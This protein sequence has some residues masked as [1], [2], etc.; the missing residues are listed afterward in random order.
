MPTNQ[1]RI[2]GQKS[3]LPVLRFLRWVFFLLLFLAIGIPYAWAENP[4]V[5]VGVYE[6]APKVFTN[7]SGKS[8]G[9]FID[10]IE[11][12]AK[13]EGWKLEYVPGT[14]AEGLDRLERGEIDL[15]PDVALTAEREKKFSFHL[16]VSS[17][18]PQRQRTAIDTGPEWKTH[19]DPGAIRSGGS[20]YPFQPRVRVKCH[21]R[22]RSGL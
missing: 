22:F 15:M 12:I 21:S 4:V 18:C 1:N 14:W 19:C 17:L 9:I 16:M 2:S 8:S 5:K 3:D 11:Y 13:S 10:I 6:N 7:E 20:F